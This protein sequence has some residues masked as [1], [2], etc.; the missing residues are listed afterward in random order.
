MTP[1]RVIVFG[2]RLMPTK[3]LRKVTRM[4]PRGFAYVLWTEDQT[5]EPHRLEGSG[6]FL[7]AGLHVVR[8]AALAELA[9]N[10]INQV[11]ICT[12]QDRSVY[13]FVKQHDGRITGY[14]PD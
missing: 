3:R 12:N 11:S 6:T 9:K 13:R 7:F 4:E 1:Y 8:A 14:M 2:T 5:A 10:G